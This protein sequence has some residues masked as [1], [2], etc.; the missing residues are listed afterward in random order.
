MD[1]RIITVVTAALWLF[2]FVSYG[3]GM[4][5]SFIHSTWLFMVCLFIPPVA[6]IYGAIE[7]AGR[8]LG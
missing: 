1:D 2:G 3:M 5:A 8:L 7:L 6:A 4:V